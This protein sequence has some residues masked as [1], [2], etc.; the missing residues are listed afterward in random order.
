MFS[1]WHLVYYNYAP[2]FWRPSFHLV[3]LHSLNTCI[4]VVKLLH[5]TLLF[6]CPKFN[7]SK[8]PQKGH[9]V[10]LWSEWR[11]GQIWGQRSLVVVACHCRLATHTVSNTHCRRCCLSLS[12]EGRKI[13]LG[14]RSV[15]YGA[16][17]SCFSW[18]ASIT[19]L[20]FT[21]RISL[22]K[23]VTLTSFI[24][25]TDRR[26]R[27]NRSKDTAYRLYS[28]SPQDGPAPLSSVTDVCQGSPPSY[29]PAAAAASRACG[30]PRVALVFVWPCPHADLSISLIPLF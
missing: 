2:Y 14:T 17:Q 1:K 18:P 29:R 6:Q 9:V 28:T 7:N 13:E 3:V 11:L 15:V 16:V 10:A 25:G 4:K 12:L 20:P 30:L 21:Q 22:I 27:S 8:L 26:P 19:S 23:Y 24:F 5:C